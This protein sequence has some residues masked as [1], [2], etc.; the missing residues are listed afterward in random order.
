M[1]YNGEDTE[2]DYYVWGNDHPQEVNQFCE[3]VTSWMKVVKLAS[4][5]QDLC[6]DHNVSLSKVLQAIG[7]IDKATEE[8]RSPEPDILRDTRGSTRGEQ[9]AERQPN[10]WK[11]W[12]SPVPVCNAPP[13]SHE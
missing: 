7:V 6:K 2:P 3:H 10:G 12:F 8:L 13:E 5:V 4:V 1:L 9:I 11:Q